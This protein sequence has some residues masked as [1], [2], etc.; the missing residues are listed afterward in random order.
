MLPAERVHVHCTRAHAGC[1]GLCHPPRAGCL[2]AQAGAEG[3]KHP[4][5]MREGFVCSANTSAV[6]HA[7]ARGP[8][9][10][11]SVQGTVGR[12]ARVCAVR[13]HVCD[14]NMEHGG[15]CGTQAHVGAQ[16]RGVNTGTAR[17]V[18]CSPPYVHHTLFSGSILL[19]FITQN[20]VGF[21][22]QVFHQGK[23]HP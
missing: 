11:P 12:A 6:T 2:Q 21:F 22:F 20:S 4:T 16:T 18:T 23:T 14:G 17:S 5:T 3:T 9:R 19:R 1:S 10:L 13:G 8:A 15:G 7:S